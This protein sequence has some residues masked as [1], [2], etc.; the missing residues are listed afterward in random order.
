MGQ[1][2]VTHV[3]SYLFEAS[4]APLPICGYPSQ[5]MTQDQERDVVD[6]VSGTLATMWRFLHCWS[7]RLAFLP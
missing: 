1:R 7:P 4:P 5:K 3:Y 2:K 6:H